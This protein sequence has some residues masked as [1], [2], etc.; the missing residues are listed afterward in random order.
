LRIV[1]DAGIEALTNERLWLEAGLPGGPILPHYATARSCLN[2]A[3]E[4]VPRG[5]YADFAAAFAAFAA[6]AA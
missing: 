3:F 4:D 2:E 5:V 1:G 6:A